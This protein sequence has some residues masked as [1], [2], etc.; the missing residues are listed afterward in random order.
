MKQNFEVVI[1]VKKDDDRYN[2]FNVVTGEKFDEKISLDSRKWA[3]ENDG[4]LGKK[5]SKSGKSFT[6]EQLTELPDSMKTIEKARSTIADG[7]KQL[8]SLE[9][10]EML[11]TCYALKPKKLVLDKLNWKYGIRAALR[12][13]NILMLGYSGCGKTMTA[14]ALAESLNRPFEKF[15]MGAMTDARSSLIGNTHYDNAKGTYFAGSVFVKAITTPGMVI[16]LD[17][18]TRMTPDAENIMM[19][20]LDP[21]Q[22]YLRIDEDPN[23]P[24]IDVAEGVTFI[25]TANVGVEYTSTRILDRATKDRFS[26]IV[27][28][29]VLTGDQEVGLLKF[30][31]PDVNV[32]YIKAI[33]EVAEFTRNDVKT[34]APKLETIISTR[35][36][37]K[38]CELA[39]D[40]F[41]FSEIMEAMVAPMFDAE[42]GAESSRAYIRQVIQ[43]NSHLDNV[44]PLKEFAPVKDESDDAVPTPVDMDSDDLFDVQGDTF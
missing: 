40:G 1:S 21:D 4:F 9:I 13:E 32:D 26:T 24:T 10:R 23:T 43:K 5:W 18:L 22:R 25:G 11:E 15:N 35:S 17:E 29:P 20:V 12:G 34:D 8:T 44:H 27:E 33:A 30:L 2:A 36:T 19:T 16:L 6:W 7:F 31:F 28:L 41:R 37:V 39:I 38:Q 42:G 14:K 3:F